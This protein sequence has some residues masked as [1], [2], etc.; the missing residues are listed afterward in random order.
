[1]KPV[2]VGKKE[3]EQLEKDFECQDLELEQKFFLCKVIKIGGTMS[4][5]KWESGSST[6][7]HKWMKEER[8]KEVFTY[9][10]N[11][12]K[13]LLCNRAEKVLSKSLDSEN[14]NVALRAGTYILDRLHPD[15]CPR[16]IRENQGKVGAVFIE[17]I[18]EGEVPQLKKVERAEPDANNP[19]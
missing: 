6:H 1:M 12:A 5:L 16:E 17:P 13:T 7:Y 9:V 19:D 11:Y 4:N 8:Y 18:F 15:Y 2:K 14:E 3:V 10:R